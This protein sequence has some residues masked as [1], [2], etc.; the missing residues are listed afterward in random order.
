[1][2]INYK[3]KTDINLPMAIWLLNDRYDHV[4]T[5]NYISA[6]GLL[7]PTQEI[8]LT[9]RNKSPASVMNVEI[10]SLAKSQMG[11]AMHDA[12]ESSW[13]NEKI[14]AKACKL[15]GI[16]DQIRDSIRLNPTAADLEHAK[17]LGELITPVY[18]ELRSIKEIMG[19]SIG[20][21]FDLVMAG[22]LHDYKSTGTYTYV[23]QTNAEKYVQ[24]GSIY[25]WLN[26]EI[27]TSMILTINYYFTDWV[28][29]KT[30][31]IKYPQ[32][33]I[34]SQHFKLW[35]YDETEKFII[36]KLKELDRHKVNTSVA[37]P[38][39]TDKQLWKDPSE[40]KY[41][42]NPT[43]ARSTK[44]FGTDIAGAN[45][46]MAK[47]GVGIVKTIPSQARACKFCDALPHC[48]QAANLLTNGLLVL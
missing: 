27:I 31:D 37:L 26:P 45:A 40:Y 35:T 2:Q 43:A 38:F 42:K 9:N 22:E 4:Y 25:K 47:N 16:N 41:Y 39:C 29:Y 19:Y 33:Q 32:A 13:F 30:N 5:P 3:N 46:L 34:M 17:A 23:K 15:L 1:M 6:T 8:V 44:N 36:N 48:D 12:I 18:M 10:A 7:K 14:R 11:T 28:A 24:Q 21:K 20:G